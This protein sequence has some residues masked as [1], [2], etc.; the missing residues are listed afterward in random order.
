VAPFSFSAWYVRT[1]MFA[2]EHARLLLVL[3]T[4][5]AVAAVAAST[6]LVVWMV[7]LL[8]GSSGRLAAVRRLALY[9][10]VLHLAAFV[11]GNLMYPTYKV[12]V[13]VEYLKDP[14]AVLADGEA[15]VRAS[16]DLQRRYGD[17]DATLTEGQL[18]RATAALPGRAERGHR[19]F[20]AKEHWIAMGLP[21]SIALAFLLRGWKPDEG[22][23]ITPVVFSF[24]LGACATLWFAAII[25]V[26]TASLRAI[27]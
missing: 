26:L 15:R 19:W 27:G 6:H 8:R 24:A 1:V 17:R 21:L 2:E 7:R 10:A 4:V 3:H 5:L 12:R 16:H 23:A 18:H 25:G 13:K 11:A 22:R 14:A 9:A 20:D